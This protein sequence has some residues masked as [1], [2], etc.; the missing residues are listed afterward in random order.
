ML[1]NVDADR[2]Q[3][4]VMNIKA[5]PSILKIVRAQ[6]GMRFV[7]VAWVTES[8][9]RACAVLDELGLG[10]RVGDELDVDTTICKDVLATHAAVAFDDAQVHP[11]YATHRTPRI[12]GFRSYVSQPI[13]LADGTHFGNLCALDAEVRDATSPKA[14]AVIESCAAILAKLLDDEADAYRTQRALDDATSTGGAREQFLAVVAHDLRNPLSTMHTAAEIML[15]GAEPKAARIGIRLKASAQR[16]TRLI[17]DLVDFS[18]GRAGSAITVVMAAHTDLSELL[19]AV[20]D[21]ARDAH[22]ALRFVSSIALGG[23]VLCDAPRLQQLLSNLLGNAV[24]YGDNTSPVEVKASIDHGR[25]CVTVTNAG[26]VIP[27]DVLDR[28]F[29]AFYRGTSS[30][31]TSMGLGL[32][33]CAQIA[34]AHGGH[35]TAESSRASGTRFELRFPVAQG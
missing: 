23:S 2:S 24:A 1:S 31:S 13:I 19:E 33:I 12:Y 5:A 15:R 18:K 26:E 11:V 25:A 4:A 20:V 17:D 22:P 29:D 21:E 10:V 34:K 8:R 32:S 16:M 35:L 27:G 14:Q 30:G 6:T 28:V 9:W 7:T 3:D